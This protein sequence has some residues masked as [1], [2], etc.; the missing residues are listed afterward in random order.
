MEFGDGDQARLLSA[1]FTR[2]SSAHQDSAPV[3]N[4]FSRAASVDAAIEKMGSDPPKS[5]FVLHLLANTPETMKQLCS[6]LE[7]RLNARPELLEGLCKAP[8]S[9]G[10]QSQ[11]GPPALRWTIAGHDVAAI[12]AQLRRPLPSQASIRAIENI[13]KEQGK[14]IFIFSGQGSELKGSW[15]DLYMANGTFSA[16][17][18]FLE[19]PTAEFLSCLTGL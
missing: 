2:A 4:V 16:R 8:Q 14:L 18:H 1:E 11:K 13:T 3:L 12:I 17:C 7:R 5:P 10:A 19:V 9:T 6:S 15:H